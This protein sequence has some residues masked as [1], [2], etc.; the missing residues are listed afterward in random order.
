MEKNKK[1][2]KRKGKKKNESSEKALTPSLVG[3]PFSRLGKTQRKAL[4]ATFEASGRV[5][6]SPA[7]SRLGLN[8]RYDFT[9]LFDI[10]TFCALSQ[11]KKATNK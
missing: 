9:A 1:R 10:N 6:S 7:T 3:I 5:S 2:M 11:E 8:Q 4:T